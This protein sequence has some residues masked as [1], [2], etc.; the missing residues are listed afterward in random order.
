MDLNTVWF[1]LIAVLYLGF[2]VLE[3]FD[4]GVGILLP[5]L[6]KTD[7]ERR[8]II[9][10]IGPHW[11]GNE[12]WLITAGGATFAAFPHWYATLFSGFYLPLFLILL[13]LILRGVAFE[14]RSKDENPKWR[15]FWDWAIFGGSLV[16]ALLFGVAFTNIM[17]GVPIDANMTYVG[18]FWNLLNPYALIGGL[19]SLLGFILHGA[20]FL[21]L[22]TDGEMMTRAQDAARKVWLPATLVLVVFIIATYFFTD[23]L[24]QLGINPGPIPIGA[25]FTMLAA[26]YFVYTRRSGWAFFMT[27]LTILFATATIFMILYPRVMVSSLDPAYSLTIYNAASSP[28]TLRVM[29]IIALIFVPI[30]LAYQ[31]WS[32]WVFRKR[33][34][35]KQELHY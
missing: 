4:F 29:S 22:K 2:F 23:V 26:G 11:D 21:S 1:I 8:V 5:F 24:Q 6:G 25:F 10:T 28:Y 7:Q 13:A 32:Y 33:I 19:T 16:P 12:V 9:N 27:T 31:A 3:G 30:V 34:T 17:A 15:T 18:G 20:V 35:A 14:F